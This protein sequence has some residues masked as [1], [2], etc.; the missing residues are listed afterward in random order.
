MINLSQNIWDSILSQ[1]PQKG[2]LLYSQVCV[3][4][5]STL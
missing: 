5:N 3:K 4:L 2:T 1:E